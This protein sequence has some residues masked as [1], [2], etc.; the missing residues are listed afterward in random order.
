MEDLGTMIQG[1]LQDPKMM[2]QILAIAGS[3]GATPAEKETPGPKPESS[4]A[5][6]PSQLMKLSGL[7]SQGN[8]DSDQQKLL[9]AL[10]P[11]L[12]GSHLAKLQRAMQAAAMAE[13]ATA[14]LGN[15]RQGGTDHV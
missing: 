4:P 5:P 2:E 12:S 8:M 6:D 10:K 7:L 13:M 9:S 11:Y 14:V 3:M 15:S 1:V